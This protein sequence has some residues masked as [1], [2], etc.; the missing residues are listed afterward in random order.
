M[1]CA[2]ACRLLAAVF[3]FFSLSSLRRVVFIV[4]GI[5]LY[6][7][8]LTTAQ[9]V[10]IY[11]HLTCLGE[12]SPCASVPS[13]HICLPGTIWESPSAAGSASLQLPCLPSHQTWQC[14]LL[15]QWADTLAP[16]SE[17]GKAPWFL[18]SPAST[19]G[20]EPHNLKGE[21]AWQHLLKTMA[22]REQERCP[23]SLIFE[24]K[25]LAGERCVF[26]I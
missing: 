24:L 13:P 9:M 10:P 6:L 18:K 19:N 16:Y 26:T 21:L 20:A 4:L 2:C 15:C 14:R 11:C 1:R 25:V 7:E 5:W 22:L 12:T 8:R 17:T 3:V 23:V